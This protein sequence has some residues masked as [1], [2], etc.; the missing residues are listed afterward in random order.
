VPLRGP[1]AAAGRW[2]RDEDFCLVAVALREEWEKGL[3]KW[4]DVASAILAVMR[5]GR[6]ARATPV[7]PAR[8]YHTPASAPAA[9]G[10]VVL[11]RRA[12]CPF[13]ANPQS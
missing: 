1:V 2:G 8:R 4:N 7:F 11:S 5:H 3:G 10:G 13:K 12:A 6:G 9:S